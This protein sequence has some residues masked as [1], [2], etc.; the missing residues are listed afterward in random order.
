MQGN[1]FFYKEKLVII[2]AK[3]I[4]IVY[5]VRNS[6]EYKKFHIRNAVNIP[7]ENIKE[8]M[9]GYCNKD[10]SIYVYCQSGKNSKKAA[11]IISELGYKNVFDIGG[12]EEYNQIKKDNKL[13][14]RQ[15]E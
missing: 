10:K 8:E 6:E 2:K 13:L 11:K 14:F 5:F 1:G 3:N 7:I 9:L 12:I 4:F 15:K